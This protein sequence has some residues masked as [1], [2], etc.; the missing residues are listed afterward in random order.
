MPGDHFRVAIIGGKIIY[1]RNGTPFLHERQWLPPIR[2]ISSAT[3][4]T[5]GSS[6]VTPTVS[7]N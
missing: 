6:L 3:L 4:Y 5:L 2:C 7:G 1:S